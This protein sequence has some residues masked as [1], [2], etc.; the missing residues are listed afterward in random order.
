[1]LS[2][3][4][5]PILSYQPVH[6]LSPHYKKYYIDILNCILTLPPPPSLSPLSLPLRCAKSVHPH[7]VGYWTQRHQPLIVWLPPA[8]QQQLQ[9]LRRPADL[10]RW[11][12]LLTHA[13]N[14][15]LRNWT[16]IFTPALAPSHCY[17][18]LVRLCWVF[19]LVRSECSAYRLPNLQASRVSV[20]VRTLKMHIAICHISLDQTV[21][22]MEEQQGRGNRVSV[23]GATV[24]NWWGGWLP[25]WKADEVGSFVLLLST[26]ALQLFQTS[27]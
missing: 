6:T 7:P 23:R 18:L 27:S 13:L 17:R 5:T 8:V 4:S 19:Q 12:H 10:Y 3:P 16:G 20:Y 2:S 14:W 26:Q 25:H 22:R 21:E 15:S 11:D 9:D 24:T 1:M